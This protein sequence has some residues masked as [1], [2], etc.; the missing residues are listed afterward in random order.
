MSESASND[1][2]PVGDHSAATAVI[3]KR[4]QATSD[5]THDAD[6]LVRRQQMPPS[7]AAAAASPSDAGRR[8]SYHQLQITGYDPHCFASSAAVS[9]MPGTPLSCIPS[10]FATTTAR[11]DAFLSNHALDTA[12]SLY[13]AQRA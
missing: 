1:A 12:E 11:A 5:V 3:N 8:H 7:A 4:Q 10:Y 9:Y 2:V 6:S 13:S